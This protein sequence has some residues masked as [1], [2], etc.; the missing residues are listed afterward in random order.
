MASID[1]KI[2]NE[3]VRRS[4][5][6]QEIESP[7][8]KGIKPETD[9]IGTHK[10]YAPEKKQQE[11]TGEGQKRTIIVNGYAYP[12]INEY[13]LQMW[14][15]DLTFISTFSYGITP[16]G[17][18]VQLEDE[19]LIEAAGA[20]G[21]QSLMVLTPLNEEG[22]FS[23]ELAKLVLENPAA[24]ANLID[25][26]LA[27]IQTKGMFGV[28][29]DFE[30][31]YEANK[32]QYVELVAQTRERLNPLGYIVTVALAP[33]Y[34]AEQQGLLYQGHDYRGMGQAANLVLLMTYEW[35]YTY[36]PPMAVAP[37]NSVRRVLDYG[38]TEIDPGKILMGIPNYGYDWTLPYVRGETRAERISNDEAVRRAERYGVEIQ[39][40]EEAQSPFFYYYDADG[41]EHVVWFEDARSMRAKL[42]LVEE[43]GFAGVSYWNIMEFFPAG[44]A[45]LNSMYN[46]AKI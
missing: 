43:Y 5:A 3:Y 39:F 10:E 23:N 28:D 13:D 16:S 42:A 1:K 6:K 14:L 7:A 29:F 25:N 2:N 24:R 17:G 30:Y 18:L 41:R 46:I 31:V 8:Y 19:H 33:K 35:G 26:I 11:E 21:V 32:E 4:I 37:I 22:A 36:G 15:N 9:D 38:I 40:D 34:S 12:S 27:N 20:K 45:V 44:S